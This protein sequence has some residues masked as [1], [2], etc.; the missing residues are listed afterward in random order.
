MRLQFQT[1]F[2]SFIEGRVID[3][4]VPLVPELLE[5]LERG[6]VKA[7][8][9]EGEELALAPAPSETAVRPRP[10]ITKGKT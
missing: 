7:L 10:R 6:I 8:P 3:V 4:E 1:S 9:A 2:G 5:W